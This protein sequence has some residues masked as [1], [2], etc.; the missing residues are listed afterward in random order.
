[1]MNNRNAYIETII[2]ILASFS[3]L[4]SQPIKAALVLILLIINY[5]YFLKFRKNKII[6]LGIFIAIFT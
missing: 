3:P 4:L 6:I 1:M 5:K 2:L